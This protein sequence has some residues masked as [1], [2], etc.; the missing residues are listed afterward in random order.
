MWLKAEY[1]EAVYIDLLNSQTHNR[2]LARPELIE[3]Y[4]PD[5][6]AGVVIVDEIQKI[7]EL[8]N[9]VHRIIESSRIQFILTGSSAR[10]LRKAGTNLL[11]GRAMTRYMHPMSVTE[12]DQKFD[13][14]TS[15]KVGHLPTLYDE[16]KSIDPVDYL[17][18]YI[19]TY[20]KEEIL[21]E[22]VT[23]NIGNFA[24]F[25][26]TASFSQG[27]VLNISAVAREASVSRKVAE[28]YFDILEDLL[29]A[30]RIPVFQKRAKRRLIQHP[31]FYFF[32]VGVYRTIRPKG[33]LDTPE[34]IDGAA[35]ETLVLQELR[36]WI[37]YNNIALSIYYWRTSNQQEVDF[38]LY[39][40]AGFVALE[41][42][43]SNRFKQEDLR[44][45]RAF[46]AD[47]P[48]CKCILLYQG[49]E[50]LYP[51]GFEVIPIEQILKNPDSLIS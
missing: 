30:H 10:K 19:Q 23:R 7:P 28:A 44:G 35:L 1:P 43:R 20:L 32:D 5:G 50:T 51:K 48:G 24:R 21:Q 37:D 3:E 41:V 25:L 9:E 16:N 47:Y 13:C 49:V 18:A 31:K 12:L 27:E 4:I 40:E 39:G 42:K 46:K 17:N 29:I 26:E 22:G 11:G 34:K 2:L 6:Y 8:L 36:A 45:L 38:I 14:E 15:L 33:P